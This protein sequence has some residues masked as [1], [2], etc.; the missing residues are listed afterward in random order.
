VEPCSKYLGAIL[1]GRLEQDLGRASAFVL[2]SKNELVFVVSVEFAV[3]AEHFTEHCGS[4]G[5]RVFV[6]EKIDNRNRKLK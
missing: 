5:L 6:K 1:L 3:F 4:R 2:S